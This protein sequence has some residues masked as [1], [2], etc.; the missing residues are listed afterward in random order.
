MNGDSVVTV[1]TNLCFASIVVELGL[2]LAA[3]KRQ[4]FEMVALVSRK[5]LHL[6]WIIGVRSLPAASG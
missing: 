1:D 4:T 3:L 6:V 2:A 5:D